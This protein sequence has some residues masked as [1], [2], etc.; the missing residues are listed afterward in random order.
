VQSDPALSDSSFATR[1]AKLTLWIVLSLVAFFATTVVAFW[2]VGRIFTDRFEWTQWLWW[3]P[4]P[5]AIGATALGL[6]SS[7]RR[8]RTTARRRQR[9]WRWCAA[10]VL[11]LL[12]FLVIEHRMWRSGAAITSRGAISIAHWNAS[13]PP[14]TLTAEDVTSRLIALDADITVLTGDYRLAHDQQVVDKL[15]GGQNPVSVGTI[16][17]LSRFPIERTQVLL[18][19]H[20]TYV[21]AVTIDTTEKLG[22]STV[23]YMVDLPSDLKVPRMP[24]ARKLREFP[25]FTAPARGPDIVIGD[26]NIPRGSASLSVLFPE[27]SHA[28]DQAGHGYGATFHRGWYFPLYHI[29]HTLVAPSMRALRYD[30]IDTG[31]A[32]HCAQ[33]TWVV[34]SGNNELQP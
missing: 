27:L 30:I 6:L 8:A 20:G 7:T 24:L 2:L 26:F 10:V 18:A 21:N 23:V 31:V 15:G 17:L 33:K 11:I 16:S 29:D 14:G 25:H 3:I 22:K 12:Y 5:M 13:A 9:M 19:V 1:A 28:F 34:A 4:T 32:R